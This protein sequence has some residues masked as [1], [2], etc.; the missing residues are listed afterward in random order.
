MNIEN[1]NIN[2]PFKVADGYFEKLKKEILFKTIDNQI[3]VNKSKKNIWEIWPI[4][5][6]A[7]LVIMAGI[8]WVNFENT[9]KKTENTL[10]EIS[11]SQT[12]VYLE[13]ENVDLIDIQSEINVEN[14]DLNLNE[15]DILPNNTETE[16]LEQLE[17]GLLN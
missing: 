11:Q 10:A 7:S 16:L 3:V 4:G 14:T 12:I 1:E 15:E 8:F 6:A 2:H 17:K 5:I 9:N 13:K